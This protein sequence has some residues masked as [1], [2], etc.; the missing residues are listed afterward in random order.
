[1]SFIVYDITFL[2]LFLAF[3]FFFLNRGKKN[4]KKEGLLL[5][6]RTSWGIKLINYVGR[7][8]KKTLKFLSYVSVTLGYFLM[9][10]MVY[11]FGKIV[12]LYFFSK[13]IVQQIKVPPI[14]P[15]FPYLPRALNLD[16]L[17]PFYFTYWILILAIIAI[18]HEFSHGIF[19]ST[20]KVKI[21]KTGF[22]FFPFFLPIFLAAFVEL[23]EKVLA[24]K[25][26]FTQL[27][28]ISAGTFANVLTA[29]LFMIALALFF[30]L[31]F[32]PTGVIYNGYASYS[33]D[34]PTITSVNGIDLENPT[35]EQIVDLLENSSFND[36]VVGEEKFVAVG[37]Y[38]VSQNLINLYPSAP[39][40][41]SKLEPVIF[42]VNNIEVTNKDMLVEELSKYSPGE[43]ITLN[44]LATDG[45]DYD[46]DVVLESHPADP[47]I[48]WL[49]IWFNE[50]KPKGMIGAL[51]YKLSSFK[52]PTT[53][54]VPKIKGLSIFIYQFLWWVVIISI[55]VALLNMLPVGIFDGGRFFYLTVFAI[56]KNEKIARKSF[57]FV[58]ALI[59]YLVLAVMIVWA[60]KLWLL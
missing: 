16:W 25:K 47:N 42:K 57:A 32:I 31:A 58:T 20:E 1:M 9:V 7:K 35:Y 49:G 48:A 38:D 26:K 15:L 54:Y 5:L 33:V 21:K 29:I 28:V 43:T 23:D 45:E 18:T 46:K 50:V 40:I 30:S 11:L 3:V 51:V 55:S 4:I 60:Y 22:G 27:A 36:V 53:R 17:P 44:V 19:A 34:V 39:A 41:N 52:D 12:W 6:Y 24:T 59:G 10:V 37:G 8:Y 56:T 2:I 14:M 13:D